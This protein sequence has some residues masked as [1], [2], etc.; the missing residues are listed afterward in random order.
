MIGASFVLWSN[1]SVLPTVMYLSSVSKWFY[2]IQIGTT[3]MFSFLHHYPLVWNPPW[4]ILGWSAV[5]TFIDAILSYLSIYTFSLYFFLDY[6]LSSLLTEFYLTHIAIYFFVT[7]RL[8]SSIVISFLIFNI[9]LTVFCR[10]IFIRHFDLYNPYIWLTMFMAISDLTCFFMANHF[11]FSIFH[12]I[13]HLLAFTL[14]ITVEAS[15]TWQ[16]VELDGL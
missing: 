13:H 5:F 3:A 2:A 7:T 16:W 6:P 8:D 4:E 12:T 1:L 14:P 10:L 15:T 11:D 9:L